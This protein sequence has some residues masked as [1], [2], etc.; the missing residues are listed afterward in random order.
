MN[1]VRSI[2]IVIILVL[3]R[4]ASLW[5]DAGAS[6]GRISGG[7]NSRCRST[8]P[9]VPPAA[10]NVA[11]NPSSSRPIAISDDDSLLVVV[12]NLDDSLS[13]INVAGDANTKVAQIEVGDEPRTFAISPDKQ[14]GVCNQSRQWNRIGH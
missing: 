9:A 1:R 14:L 4:S 5:R 8:Q 7:S 10:E 2:S 6:R 3:L 12:N 13:V 11:K